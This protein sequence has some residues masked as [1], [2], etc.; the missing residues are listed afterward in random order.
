[1]E[2]VGQNLTEEKILP[3]LMKIIVTQVRKED[4]VQKDEFGSID[5]QKSNLNCDFY[6]EAT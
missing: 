3:W 1:M 6:M 4:L 5:Y 2:F